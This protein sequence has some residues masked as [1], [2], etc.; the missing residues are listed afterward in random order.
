MPLIANTSEPGKLA[1]TSRTHELGGA[2]MFAFLI[3]VIGVVAAYSF[4]RRGAADGLR[5]ALRERDEEETRRE[6]GPQGEF[7]YPPA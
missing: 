1:V 5:D 4:A 2:E 7:K 6:R 3:L